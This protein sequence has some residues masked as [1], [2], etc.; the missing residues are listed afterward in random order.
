MAKR[1]RT[2][3]TT[4]FCDQLTNAFAMRDDTITTHDTWFYMIFLLENLNFST[5]KYCTRG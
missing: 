4:S 5:S 2:E 1:E 3:P